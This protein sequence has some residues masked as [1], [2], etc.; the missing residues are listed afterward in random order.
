MIFYNGTTGSLGRYFANAARN[1]STSAVAL[2]SRL[3]DRAGLRSEIETVSG[4]SAILILLAAKVSVPW[5]E[6]HPEEARRTNVEDTV[7]FVR[8]FVEVCRA[9]GVAPEVVYVSSAHLYARNDGRIHETDPALPRSVYA[10]TKLEAESALRSLSDAF[11]FD[12]RVARVFGLVAPIQP[13]N[14]V[15]HSLLRRAREMNLKDI[16]GLSNVRDYLDSRDVCRS[17]I[18]IAEVPR[19]R[20]ARVCPDG[21]LNVCAGEGITIRRLAETCLEALYPASEARVLRSELSEAPPRADDVPRIVGSG[22]RY[23]ALFGENPK[24]IS[25]EET[26]RDAVTTPKASG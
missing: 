16:P 13:E 18:R 2:R 20:F 12:L 7:E 8:V 21:V 11:G 3:E 23:R 1:L 19:D 9:K 17:L 6:S 14:Y 24:T 22:D 10:R 26:V 15:L 5:C 25:I 4:E